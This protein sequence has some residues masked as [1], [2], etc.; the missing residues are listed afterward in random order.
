MIE[1][2]RPVFFCKNQSFVALLTV[3]VAV[4]YVIDVIIIINRK[5]NQQTDVA[6]LHQDAATT[7]LKSWQRDECDH[8]AGPVCSADLRG[9]LCP[10]VHYYDISHKI[11]FQMSQCYTEN[12]FSHIALLT[13]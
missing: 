11:K 4:I 2:Q 5:T 8:W 9:G 12:I 3:F 10:A 6:G 13:A 7:W 1:S